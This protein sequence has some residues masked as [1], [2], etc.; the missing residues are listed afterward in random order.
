MGCQWSD[1]RDERPVS[2]ETISQGQSKFS[3]YRRS[4]CAGSPG[5]TRGA[6]LAR[7]LEYVQYGTDS[8][9][10]KEV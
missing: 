5:Y 1:W 10:P 2:E 7:A 8:D 9:T 6:D 3:T 4:R